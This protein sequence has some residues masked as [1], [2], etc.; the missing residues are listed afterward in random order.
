MNLAR[1][2]QLI[3]FSFVEEM[4]GALEELL[5]DDAGSPLVG[6]EWEDYRTECAPVSRVL[7][8]PAGLADMW[9]GEWHP[10]VLVLP[11]YSF[12]YLHLTLLF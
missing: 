12:P 7:G 9:I 11:K 8:H 4:V 3:L 2:K 6:M 1:H 5:R 10:P